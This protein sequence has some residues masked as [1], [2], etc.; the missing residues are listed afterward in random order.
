MDRH[1]GAEAVRFARSV[2]MAEAS[3]EPIPPPLTRGEFSINRGAF[4]TLS[5]YPSGELRG[6]IGYPYPTMPLGRVLVESARS[7]CH[8][9]RFPD[10]EGDEARAVTVEVTILS[11]PV[12]I[13]SGESLPGRIV[14]GRDGLMIECM[15]RRG[16]LLPQVPLE[17]GWDAMGYLDAL[18]DK[19]GL[20]RGVWS[21][22]DCRVYSFTGE[23]FSETVPFGDVNRLDSNGL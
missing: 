12:S 13:G 7:A 8:D 6:C 2:V 9:P 17:W 15:G 19:A 21:R 14:V 16:L 23:V 20:P 5:T 3:F 10:L 22:P 11:P 1:T 4:V 18:C